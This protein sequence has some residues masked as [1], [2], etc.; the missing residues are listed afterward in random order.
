MISFRTAAGLVLGLAVVAAPLGAQAHRSWMVPSST[1]LSGQEAWVTV[2]AA[3][4][5]T[6][7]HPDHVPM[8][9]DGVT[10]LGPDGGV[11][12]PQN[13]ATGKFRSTFDAAL[14]KPGTYKIFAATEGLSAAY[15]LN[16]EVKRWRG[17]ISEAAT[18]IPAGATEGK[19][20]L[21]QRRIETFVTL[22]APSAGALK[23]TGKGLELEPITHPND[24]VAG[25]AARFRLLLDGKPASNLEVE[26]APGNAR[27]RA[28]PDLMEL[29]TGAD[30]VVQITWPE[31][32]MYW[33]EASA[34][35]GPSSVAGAE[36]A[37]TYVATFEVLPN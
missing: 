14:T 6:L 15:K 5:N 2:D 22:G 37:A 20:T 10:I 32:G 18:A 11:A 9:L 26:V 17:Q 29:K 35:G 1:V 24:L 23:P 3:V 25:E 12:Q 31:A 34:R 13:A 7:F 4:S 36:R 28:A 8:R 21:N 27:Y 16:G 30:G 33:L 19:L